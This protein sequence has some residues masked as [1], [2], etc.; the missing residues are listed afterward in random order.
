[1]FRRRPNPNPE[2]E[3][4]QKADWFGWDNGIIINGMNNQRD[5]DFE[6]FERFERF[7]KH[8]NG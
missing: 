8:A 3:E 6:I 7:V 2:S 4:V 5:N 1:M